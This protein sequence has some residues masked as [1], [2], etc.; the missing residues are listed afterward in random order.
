MNAPLVH[1]VADVVRR[2]RGAVEAREAPVL[3]P[4]GTGDLARIEFGPGLV[5]LLGGAPGS[6]KTAF[7]L[8]A[9]VDILRTQSAVR[10]LVANV[11][12]TSEALVN[13]A[14]AR[15]SGIPQDR[16]RRRALDPGD[17]PRFAH[18]VATIEALEDRLGFMEGPFTLDRLADAAE[19]MDANLLV[20]DY[21]QRFTTGRG[22]AGEA[23]QNVT[24]VMNGLRTFANTGAG[25]LALAAL[26]RQRGPNGSTY[27][28]AE[29]M[30]AFRDS[31]ELEYG[32]DEAFVLERASPEFDDVATLLHAKC[33]H[34]QLRNVELRFHGACQAF[35]PLF[36]A[37]ASPEA[38]P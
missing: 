37:S 4:I 8:Q 35:E 5:I 33:R 13:R 19:A 23:R 10:A 30:T 7:A 3:W 26:A 36:K 11:E 27:K 18:G 34:G 12:M 16:I 38:A 6:G 29:P 14:L 22:D 24:E 9:T 32:G 21:V 2:V 28:V 17:E 20:V 31:S 1:S 25:V 15:L